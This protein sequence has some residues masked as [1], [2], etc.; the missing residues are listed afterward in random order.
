MECRTNVGG[1]MVVVFWLWWGCAQQEMP[2]RSGLRSQDS[3]TIL[4]ANNTQYRGDPMVLPEEQLCAQDDDCT[5]V[6]KSCCPCNSGGQQ[7]A[8]HKQYVQELIDRRQS[9]CAS[10]GCLDVINQGPSCRA[11]EALCQHGTCRV[12]IPED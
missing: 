5:L 12:K 7:V 1:Q 9:L 10:M 11:T 6:P 3:Q 2:D 8:I 4:G